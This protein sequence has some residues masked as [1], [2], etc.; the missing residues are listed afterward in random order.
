MSSI[1]DCDLQ[2]LVNYMFLTVAK[3]RNVIGLFLTVNNAMLVKMQ[4]KMIEN[5]PVIAIWKTKIPMLQNVMSWLTLVL[6]RC[7]DEIQHSIDKQ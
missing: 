4:Q 3:Q 1:S 7:A 2:Q 5:K 6:S